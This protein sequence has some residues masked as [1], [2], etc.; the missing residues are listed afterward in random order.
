MQGNNKEMTEKR[1]RLELE[2][3]KY[4]EKTQ[5]RCKM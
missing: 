4:G 2:K 1:H 3:E 5:I